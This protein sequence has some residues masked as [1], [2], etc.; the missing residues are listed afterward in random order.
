MGFAKYLYFV[1]SGISSKWKNHFLQ[2]IKITL[3]LSFSQINVVFRNSLNGFSTAYFSFPTQIF[4][5]IR[6]FL[7]IESECYLTKW[8][9]WH[10][11]T[12]LLSFSGLHLRLFLNP[13]WLIS[14]AHFKIPFCS[15]MHEISR[16]SYSETMESN[17][18]LFPNFLIKKK[19]FSKNTFYS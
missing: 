12:N 13:N 5:R 8:Y 7:S 9:R 11:V 3:L 14:E 15:Q 19:D 18:L 2:K 17:C 16:C 1:M 4:Y 10:S 6:I